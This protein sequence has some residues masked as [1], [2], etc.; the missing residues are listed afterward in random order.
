[1]LSLWAFT[2]L[3]NS[4]RKRIIMLSFYSVLSFVWYTPWA[5][6]GRITG[7]IINLINVFSFGFISK[8]KHQAKVNTLKLFYRFYRLATMDSASVLDN[9]PTFSS[10]P[11]KNS[12][13]ITKC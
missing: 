2:Y 1:M 5:L 4:N 7:Q 3:M 10:P 6:L 9:S 8:T 12:F 11:H 13:G